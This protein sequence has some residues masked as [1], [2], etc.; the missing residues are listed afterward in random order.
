M[1]HQPLAPRQALSEEEFPL[2]ALEVS[3]A[4]LQPNRIQLELH[5][6]LLDSHNLPL[7]VY[8]N[9]HSTTVPPPPRMSLGSRSHSHSQLVV[10][11]FLNNRSNHLCNISQASVVGNNQAVRSKR[12][13]DCQTNTISSYPQSTSASIQLLRNPIRNRKISS[14]SQYSKFIQC[15]ANSNSSTYPMRCLGFWTCNN[16][17]AYSQRATN[18]KPCKSSTRT[19]MRIL[20]LNKVNSGSHRMLAKLQVRE[21][22]LAQVVQTSLEQA[23]PLNLNLQYL[24]KHL[25]RLQLR[26]S[27]AVNQAPSNLVD[28]FPNQWAHHNQCSAQQVLSAHKIHKASPKALYS[29]QFRHKIL[30]SLE[31]AFLLLLLDR[32]SHNRQELME[33]HRILLV[34]VSFLIQLNNLRL[35]SNRYLEHLKQASQ[36]SKPS[37]SALSVQLVRLN[38]N[39]QE[40]ASSLLNQSKLVHFSDHKQQLSHLR[41]QLDLS[42]LNLSLERAR[43]AYLVRRRPPQGFQL[44]HHKVEAYSPLLLSLIRLL[45]LLLRPRQVA[46][47]LHLLFL[48]R[49]QPRIQVGLFLDHQRSK[50][51]KTA[52][53]GLLSLISNSLKL[54]NS[55]HRRST[56]WVFFRAVTRTAYNL[57]SWA[58]S[59]KLLMTLNKNYNK[60]AKV[61]KLPLASTT[62]ARPVTLRD[63][64][65]TPTTCETSR[66]TTHKLASLRSICHSLCQSISLQM[67]SNAKKKLCEKI[68]ILNT[69]TAAISTIKKSQRRGKNARVKYS[70]RVSQ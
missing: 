69:A 16:K 22:S 25:D 21:F 50:M 24:N 57:V 52:C 17:R 31:A 35:A 32:P 33:L 27:V 54:S 4:F 43:R 15:A 29:R 41:L 13:T 14:R 61:L 60:S 44:K 39:N 20:C 26:S 62:L 42:S 37:Y 7:V 28:F 67:I 18:G 59:L 23:S 70:R 51:A 9:L 47:G 63:P 30:S 11:F 36:L 46:L 58:S 56:Q 45:Q 64:K 38:S 65:N 49:K 55:K 68:R 48:V 34:E 12:S 5:K 53:L 8:L 40:A 19:K 1:V 6:A 2:E 10:V 66:F 3:L